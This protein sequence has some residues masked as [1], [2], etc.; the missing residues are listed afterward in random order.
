M[1]KAESLSPLTA[2]SVAEG[3]EAAPSP[4]PAT[5]GDLVRQFKDAYRLHQRS[6]FRPG[7]H[8]VATYRLARWG[9]E[10][11]SG[12]ARGFF[13][14]LTTPLFGFIRNFYGIEFSPEMA[15]GDGFHFPHHGGIVLHPESR[16]GEN[17][18]IRQNVTV[19]GINNQR[20]HSAPTFGN[21]VEIGA[22]AV[23]IGR[24][25]IGDDVRIGPNAVVMMNV[26]AGSKVFGNPA[27]I[28]PPTKD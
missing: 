19:G 24:V 25:R 5:F 20:V 21:N 23:I 9:R 28:I 16:F 1:P 4:E 12:L 14:L 17:C 15:A 3:R 22:G 26:P 27:R 7:F 2:T 18:M 8:A 13:H 11:K 10:R 6:I